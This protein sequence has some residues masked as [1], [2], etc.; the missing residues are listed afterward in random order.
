LTLDHLGRTD[1]DAGTATLSGTVTCSHP[2]TTVVGGT[3]RQARGTAITE[4]EFLVT[5]E[6]AGTSR[7]T[8]TAG[9][10][11]PTFRPGRADVSATVGGYE[12]IS[13]QAASAQI[14]AV[15]ALTG[16]PRPAELPGGTP[17]LT[18]ARPGILR[19]DR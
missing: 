16:A 7:F 11:T 15:L 14:A 18:R 2:G 13:R 3:L 8:V 19:L 1:L 17:A 5:V 6:C 12:P 4:A 9:E 10:W